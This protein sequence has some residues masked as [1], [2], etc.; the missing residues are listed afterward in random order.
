MGPQYAES[1]ADST[2]SLEFHEF[3]KSF[4]FYFIL[5]FLISFI[6]HGS[7]YGCTSLLASLMPIPKY[8]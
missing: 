8:L 1:S 5:L 2:L 6:S 7:D 4:L 3:V